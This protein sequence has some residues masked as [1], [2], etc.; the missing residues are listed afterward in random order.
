MTPFL[1]DEGLLFALE[2]FRSTRARRRN[3]IIRRPGSARVAIDRRLLELTHLNVEVLDYT[4]PVGDGYE[5]FHA[6]VLLADQDLAYV[7]SANMTAFARHSM[8]LGILSD[9]RAA[10]VVA[11]IV[12]AVERIATPFRGTSSISTF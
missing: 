10:H 8:E 9:G 5:T 7:G 4:L 6:K 3:L 1:N 12:R 11:S 2:L